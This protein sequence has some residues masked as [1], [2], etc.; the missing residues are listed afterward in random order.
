MPDIVRVNNQPYSWNSTRT[1]LLAQPWPGVVEVNYA[2]K[3]DVETVYSQTQDGKPIGAT[4]GQY[5]TEGCSI[6]MLSDSAAAF[7]AQL[8]A[9][10]PFIGSYGRTE[11]PFVFTATESLL[12]GGL[13]IVVAA[14]VCR[15]IGRKEA[16]AKGVETLVTELTLWMKELT[17]NGVS[18][19]TSA[20]PGIP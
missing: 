7:L 12:P 8:S 1:L 13:P 17:V 11:F 14:P 2:E 5:A 16:R 15:V 18:M 9:L 6:K 4:A 20:V 10:P 19:W 3:L